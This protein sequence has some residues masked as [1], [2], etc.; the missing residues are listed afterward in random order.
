MPLKR[1]SCRLLMLAGPP[2]RDLWKRFICCFVALYCFPGCSRTNVLYEPQYGRLV[3]RS[4][5]IG[6]R[7]DVWA[8]IILGKALDGH[9]M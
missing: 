2:R 1:E 3:D 8:Y 6:C 9:Y 7:L 5:P 4:G